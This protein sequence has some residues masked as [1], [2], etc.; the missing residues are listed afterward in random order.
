MFYDQNQSRIIVSYPA[1]LAA[2]P[3]AGDL[4]TEP[5]RNALGLY[6]VHEQPPAYD[7]LTHTLALDGVEL[8]EGEYRAR[9]LLIALTPEQM[10]AMRPQRKITRLAFRNRFSVAEKTG[11]EM[12]SLDDPAAPMAQRQQAAMLRA[13]LAD[14][15]AANFIDLE[16]Q[17]TRAGVQLLEQLGLL[18]AGRALEILDAPELAEEVERGY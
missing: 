9:Y 14:V 2:Y 4:S 18:G 11:L 7:P 15:A 5:A 12:A 13:Y 10:Q 16:R 17:D 1:L 3:D 8:V 6:L